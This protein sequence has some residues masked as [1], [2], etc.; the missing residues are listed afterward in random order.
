[1]KATDLD[2]GFGAIIG[3][4]LYSFDVGDDGDNT[5]KILILVTFQ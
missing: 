3:K 2:Q 5:G 1:M 4:A